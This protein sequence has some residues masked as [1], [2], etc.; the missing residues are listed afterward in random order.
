M[1]APPP[2]PD[3][4][5][6]PD[7][8]EALAGALVADDA[9]VTGQRRPP[10]LE[11]GAAARLAVALHAEVDRGAAARAEAGARQGL[12]VVC[13]HGCNGCCE[14][15]VLVFQP[16][17]IAIARWLMEP[18]NHAARDRFLAAYPAW[19]RAAGDSPRRLAELHARGD[20]AAFLAAHRA[21]WRRRLLCAFNHDGA[22]T[23]YPVRPINCRHAHAVETHERCSG[24]NVGGRPAA[25]LAFPPLDDYLIGADRL[26]RAAHH[27]VGG[28]RRRAQALCD[29]VHRALQ[30]ELAAARRA[31]RDAG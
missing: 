12:P 19:Q 4:P 17:A 31:A 20:E 29:A 15:L 30:S 8:I 24:A 2:E 14:E 3:E 6:E 26:L 1:G 22:C 9:F 18:A 13:S 10:R 28:E 5:D 7:D 11:R 25:R 16:E 23:I 21:Q 27:A